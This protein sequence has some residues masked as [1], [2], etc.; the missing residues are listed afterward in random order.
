M[1]TIVGDACEYSDTGFDLVVCNSLL[2]QVGGAAAGSN[3]RESSRLPDRGPG[4]RPRTATLTSSRTGSS[5]PSSG[6]R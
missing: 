3:W 2:E 6:F 1:T 4:S 5:P